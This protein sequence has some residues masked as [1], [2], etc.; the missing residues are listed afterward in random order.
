MA[1]YQHEQKELRTIL[2]QKLFNVIFMNTFKPLLASTLL[3]SDVECTDNAVLSAM[4][5]LHYPVLATV[6]KDGIRALRLKMPYLASRTLKWIPNEE[7]CARAIALPIGY[8]ME[9]WSPKLDY[10][11]IQSIVM[12]EK[13]P[14][15][16]IYNFTCW[17]TLK[18]N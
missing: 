2:A 17:I 14:A 18:L 7:L 13:A 3:P 8:D 12:T 16:L 15:K 9:L 1:L 10:N 4:K 5:Q 11:S 6:K